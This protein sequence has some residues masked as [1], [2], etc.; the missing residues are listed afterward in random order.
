MGHLFLFLLLVDVADSKFPALTVNFVVIERLHILRF[1]M[2]RYASK[3]A[4]FAFVRDFL[5]FFV[6]VWVFEHFIV[7][8]SNVDT[9]RRFDRRIYLHEN[10][11]EINSQHHILF[12]I[13]HYIVHFTPVALHCISL[14]IL[15][16]RMVP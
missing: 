5:D 2:L 16:V 1:M 4:S 12:T 15:S 7:L 14:Y 8:S 9:P 3:H 11:S 6:G 13:Q 10:L